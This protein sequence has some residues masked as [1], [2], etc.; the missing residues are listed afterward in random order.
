MYQNIRL[1]ILGFVICFS[2]VINEAKTDRAN[3]F[4]NAEEEQILDFEE[5]P[6]YGNELLSKSWKSF[7]RDNKFRLARLKD[8]KFSEE[9]KQL[10]NE[11]SKCWQFGITFKDELVAMIIK[12]DQH[13]KAEP[14]ISIV[15]FR[16]IYN[17]GKIILSVTNPVMKKGHRLNSF[18][19]GKVQRRKENGQD[20]NKAKR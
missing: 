5:L 14:K 17:G 16:P 10:M 18:G 20:R 3:L 7:L 1:I 4:P 12:D 11:S 9:A 8:M 15:V 19:K 2:C 13:F 6:I